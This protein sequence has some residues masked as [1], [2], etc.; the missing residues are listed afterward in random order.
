[1]RE[2]GASASFKKLASGFLMKGKHCSLAYLRPNG[3]RRECSRYPGPEAGKKQEQV[4]A[5][6]LSDAGKLLIKQ[7]GCRIVIL[8]CQTTNRVIKCVTTY[9]LLKTLPKQRIDANHTNFEYIPVAK[10][11]KNHSIDPGRY[12]TYVP[13]CPLEA[14]SAS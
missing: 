8:F 12:H 1:M 4:S 7:L 14:D 3:D 6:W 13:S 5:M 9:F 10:T 11:M 2:V